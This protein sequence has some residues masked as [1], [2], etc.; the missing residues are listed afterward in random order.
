MK[1]VINPYFLASIII[2]CHHALRAELLRLN[3]DAVL[4]RA[5]R[6]DQ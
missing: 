2:A 5:P 3:H 4:V 1:H 6:A